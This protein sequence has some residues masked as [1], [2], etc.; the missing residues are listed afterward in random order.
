VTGKKSVPNLIPV[1]ALWQNNAISLFSAEKL[2]FSAEMIEGAII[3]LYIKK[4]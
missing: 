3:D 1:W 2:G 4:R